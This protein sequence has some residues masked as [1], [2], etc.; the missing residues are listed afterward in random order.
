LSGL[1][2]G[3]RR[4]GA[5]DQRRDVLVRVRDHADQA[6]D[7]RL[8]ARGHQDLAQHAGAERLH[9]HVGLVGLDLGEHVADLDRVAFVLAPLDDGA[10]LH[11]RR[12][13]GQHD[14]GDAHRY[15][16]CFTAATTFSG[17]G[18]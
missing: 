5:R 4:A 1:G 17:C 18:R 11:R 15:R 3:R 13:L 8:A 2:L 10:L 9:L 12:Q 7:R 6:A 14:L 16:T